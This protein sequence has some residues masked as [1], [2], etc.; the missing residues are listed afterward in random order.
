MCESNSGI[1]GDRYAAGSNMTM[2]RPT[3]CRATEFKGGNWKPRTRPLRAGPHQVLLLVLLRTAITLRRRQT[4]TVVTT[5]GARG[6]AGGGLGVAHRRPVWAVGGPHAR[7]PTNG[8]ASPCMSNELL[9]FP[10]RPSESPVPPT[11]IILPSGMRQRY[12][13]MAHAPTWP[14][15]A[16]S[17]ASNSDAQ[18]KLR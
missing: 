8:D 18:I 12:V 3:W 2:S 7:A 15:V 11:M 10:G 13:A 9:R 1:C 14:S 5:A 6:S 4:P 16:C 17:P